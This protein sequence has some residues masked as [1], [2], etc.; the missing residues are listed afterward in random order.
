MLV[1]VRQIIKG[2]VDSGQNCVTVIACC[3]AVKV[4][5]CQG[6]SVAGTI[7]KL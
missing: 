3:G 4:N 2:I 6:W 7:P 5:E 1:I